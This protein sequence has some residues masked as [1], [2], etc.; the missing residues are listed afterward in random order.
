MTGEIDYEVVVGVIHNLLAIMFFITIFVCVFP[1]SMLMNK[2]PYCLPFMNMLYM[3]G[4][5]DCFPTSRWQIVASV[6]L[7]SVGGGSGG[8][9]GVVGGGGL[10]W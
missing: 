1:S 5:C 10:G 9:G 6:T 3:M 8:G 2:R 4:N 7:D